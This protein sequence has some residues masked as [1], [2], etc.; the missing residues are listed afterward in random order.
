MLVRLLTRDDARQTP[1][2]EGFVDKGG[3][4]SVLALAEAVRLLGSVYELGT[5]DQAR[6]V[7]ML[8]DHSQLVLQDREV[9]AAALALFTERPALG[10]SDCLMVEKARKSGHT[11]LG[12]FDRILAKV[13]GADRL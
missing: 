5:A 1:A 11:P 10:Y 12:T 3:W 8:L 6:V 2:A 7:K 9:V 13:D 4:V